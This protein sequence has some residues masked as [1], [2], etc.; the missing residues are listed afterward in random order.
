MF[1]RLKFPASAMIITKALIKVATFDLIPTELIDDLLWYFP[2]GEAY[3]LS[4]ETVGLDS[5]LFLKN[6]GFILY[7]IELHVVFVIIHATF[8][9]CRNSCKCSTKIHSTF[10][11]YLYYNGSMRFYMEV[12]FDVGLLTCLNVHMADWETLFFAEKVS[13]YMSVFFLVLVIVLPIIFIMYYCCNVK[14]WQTKEFKERCGA[15]LEGTN[16]DM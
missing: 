1:E 3:S 14:D 2:E 5:T 11:N 6:I 15:A 9:N 4:F 13:N 10:G 12:F 8:H 16:L 7:M